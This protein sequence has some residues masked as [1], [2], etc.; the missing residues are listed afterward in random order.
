MKGRELA[1]RF[2]FGAGISAVAAVAGIVA[3]NR[4]AGVL[5]GF[6]AI[7]PAS[8]TLIEKKDG[9][10]EA[11]VDATGATLGSIALIAFAVVA[12]WILPRLPALVA[13]LLAAGVWLALAL[14]LY[15][16][17]VRLPRRRKRPATRARPT[18]T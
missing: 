12:A 7:L 8:L 4:I 5:L 14:L 10:H 6:P 2:A 1:I 18:S 13:L 17:I 3:G 9:R 11:A 16:L 15:V